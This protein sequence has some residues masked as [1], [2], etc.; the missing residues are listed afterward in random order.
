[1]DRIFDFVCLTLYI[2][3]IHVDPANCGYTAD[4]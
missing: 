4:R 1:M 2:L 3:H